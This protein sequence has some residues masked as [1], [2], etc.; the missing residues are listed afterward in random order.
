MTIN[1][2]FIFV[3]KTLL[4]T[5]AEMASLMDVTSQTIRNWEKNKSVPRINAQ[6][7]LLSICAK[8]NIIL[9]KTE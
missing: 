8:E 5:Q 4:L 2:Q 9:K 3:R 6:R 1:E 7:K